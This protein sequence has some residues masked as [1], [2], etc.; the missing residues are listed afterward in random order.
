MSKTKKENSVTKSL[1]PTAISSEDAVIGTCLKDN[2]KLF[3]ILTIVESSDFYEEYKKAIIREMVG[4]VERNESFD[5]ILIAQQLAGVSEFDKAGGQEFLDNLPVVAELK[6][7]AQRIR[8]ESKKRQAISIGQE[9]LT[10]Q[11][12]NKADSPA[13]IREL[14]AKQFELDFDSNRHNDYDSVAN[15]SDNIVR[16]AFNRSLIK[17]PYTGLVTGFTELDDATGGLQKSDLIILAA[18][19]SMGKAQPLTAKIVTPSG[20]KLMGNITVGD[21][22]INSKGQKQRVT[23]IFPQGTKEVFRVVFNDET[24]TESCDDH[25]WLTQNASE[26][27]AGNSGSVKTLKDIRKSLV[28]KDGLKTRLSHSV[29]WVEPVEFDCLQNLNIPVKPYLLGVYL[30]DGS[31]SGCVRIHKGETDIADKISNLLPDKDTI[32]FS[33]DKKAFSIIRKNYNRDISE[34]CKGLNELGLN[35]KKSYEKFVPADY[36]RMPVADRIELLRGIFD[37][38]GYVNDNFSGIEWSTASHSL[39]L[40]VV[41]LVRSLG[42][43]ITYDE[44]I[45]SYSK[46]GESIETRWQYRA[47]ISFANGIIPVSSK[48]HLSKWKGLKRKSDK[49][50]KTVVS[51]GFRTCQCITVDSP[52]SLYVTDDYILTHNS[53][54]AINICENIANIALKK[55]EKK[56]CVVFS[57]EMSRDALINRMVSSQGY[58]DA[59][60]IRSGAMNDDEWARYIMAHR[61]LKKTSIIID[62][63]AGISPLKMKM[64]CRRILA[65]Q[66]QLDLIVVDYMQLMESSRKAESRQQEITQISR[67]LKGLARELNVPII[68]LSQLSRAPEGRADH[69]PQLSDLRESGSLEQDADIVAF[70]YREEYY[71]PLPENEM[72]AELIISKHRNGATGTLALGFIKE[73]TKFINMFEG[74]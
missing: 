56:V 64:K 8:T 27:K 46:N 73:M 11:I 68:A 22:I 69:H 40:D 43:R 42:G 30:G 70:L 9:I 21:I 7:H 18:R 65:E 51:V 35:N 2:S 60:K 29:P 34:T 33:K 38:D 10:H 31:I 17:S 1:F 63:E 74:A 25:L 23:G 13:K 59:N 48:K 50:I 19:P 26:R 54:L 55:G 53:A 45:G 37:T 47:N 6:T 24:S 41:D 49:R 39:M 71:K 5:S 58:I 4:F 57:L 61:H 36:L 72:Q 44:R 67:E 14:Q 62:E 28:I 20:W 32:S 16:E 52:D 15:V 66:K 3:E 12:A